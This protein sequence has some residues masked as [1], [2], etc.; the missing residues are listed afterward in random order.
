MSKNR[1][2]N[3]YDLT[4]YFKSEISQS[5]LF[6]YPL[7]VDVLTNYSYISGNLNNNSHVGNEGG[8]AILYKINGQLVHSP[9]CPGDPKTWVI[10]L[11]LFLFVFVSFSA[12]N[13]HRMEVKGAA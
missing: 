9:S 3:Y 6:T 12:T 2:G 11:C 4:L 7:N 1:L 13:L 8:G 5:L 10:C